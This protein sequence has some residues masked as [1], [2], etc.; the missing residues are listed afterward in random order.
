[1]TTSFITSTVSP[2][3]IITSPTQLALAMK[4]WYER[5]EDDPEGFMTL[6]DA[7]QDQDTPAASA[8]YLIGILVELNNGGK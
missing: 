2:D 4:I 3:L 7:L 1:M 8:Q 6:E 5:Y